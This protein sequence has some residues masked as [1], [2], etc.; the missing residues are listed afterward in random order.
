MR[1]FRFEQLNTRIC[2]RARVPFMHCLRSRV[3]YFDRDV[4]D[5]TIYN[6]SWWLKGKRR[7]HIVLVE[8]LP[9]ASL[10]HSNLSYYCSPHYRWSIDAWIVLTLH[11]TRTMVVATSASIS[12]MVSRSSNGALIEDDM[13]TAILHDSSHRINSENHKGTAFY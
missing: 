10:V 7:E 9:I 2:W 8:W 11:W 5:K 1:G 6:C 4:L 13:E 3:I 12:R